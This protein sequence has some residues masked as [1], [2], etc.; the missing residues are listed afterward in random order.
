MQIRP[1]KAVV[2]NLNL[3]WEFVQVTWDPSVTALL[4]RLGSSKAFEASP[5]RKLYFL[6]PAYHDLVALKK[7]LSIAGIVLRLTLQ[8]AV[9][10]CVFSGCFCHSAICILSDIVFFFLDDNRTYSEQNWI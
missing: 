3:S 10:I 1:S 2:S 6:G 9:Y 4:R 7:L 8:G 5:R